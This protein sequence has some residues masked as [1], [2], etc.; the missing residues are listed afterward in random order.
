LKRSLLRGFKGRSAVSAGEPEEPIRSELFSIERLEQHAESLA[1]AQPVTPRPGAGRPLAARLRDNGRVLLAAYRAIG[2]AIRE[3]RAITPAAEWLVDN[4]H[5]VEEQIREIHDDLPRGFYRQLPKLADGPLA[6]YPRVF[7]LAWAFVAHTDSLFDPETL[8]R[9]VRAYQRVQP[10]T[11]GELWA[12]AITLRIVLVENLRR[13]AERIVRGRAA[14]QEADAL[15]DRLLGVG[16]REAEPIA[17][18][19]RGLD[20]TPLP[21]NFAAQLVQRLRDQDPAVTPAVRWL[22]DRL[23]AQGT[24]ADEIVRE[25]HQRQGA[26]NVTVRNVITSMRLLSAVDWAQFFE[27]V[28]LVDATLRAGS[29]FAAM[30]FPTRDRY[31][32][33]I[34]ALARGSS[35]S[36]LDVAGRALRAAKH[37]GD[38]PRSGDATVRREQDPGYYLIGR[39]RRAFEIELGFRVP[40][41]D[42]L[43]RAYAAAGILGY[44]GTVAIITACIL[45]PCVLVMAA[46]GV[47]GLALVLLAVLGLVPASDAAVALVNRHVTNRFDPK[48]LPAW[49]LREGVPPSL[50]TM[51]V[52]PTLLTT[53]AEIEEQVERL[54]VRYLASAEDDVRFALLSDWTDSSSECAPDDDALLGTATAAIDRLNQRYHPT[55]DGHRFILLHRRRVWN[56]REGKWIGWERKRGKLHELNRLLRG[57]TD[58]TF[59]SANGRP[60]VVPSGVRY[61]ITLDA[62]TRL[63]RGAA[64]Q[65]V[66]KMAHP[67]NRPELDPFTGRVVEGYGVLQPRVTPSLPTG[68][69]GSVFQRIFSGPSGIDPYAFAVSDV[70]QDLLGEGSF[71]GKGIYDVD[72]FEAALAGRVPENTLLSHDLLEGIFARAGLASDIE[73]VEEFPSRY[74]V[75]AAR[76]HRW[77][78]GDWQLL[79]WIFGRGRH[80]SGDPAR[81]P[82]PVIGRWKMLDNLRRTLSAPASFLALVAGWMLPAAPAVL[83]TGFVLAMI[84]LPALLPFVAGIVPR[85][86]GISKRSHLRAVGADLALGL[87]QTGLLLTLLAHQAWLMTDAI[88]RTL[89]R[90]CARQGRMLEWVTAAQAKFS[91][92][93]DIPGFYRRMAGGVAL[94]AAAAVVA[95]C[96]GYEGGLIAAPFVMLWTVSPVVAQWVSRPPPAA[97]PKPVSAANSHALRLIARRTWRFFETFVVA[98]DHMLPPDNFQEDPK[99]VVAHRTS[100]TNLGLY[101]LSVVAA[102]D[103]G[104][105]GTLE[106]VERLDATL[107]TMNHLERVRGHFYNWY[108]T[109]DLRPLDPT[110]VSS[111]DS[112]N[113]A[114]HLIALGSACRE[115]IGRPVLSPERFAGIADAVGLARAAVGAL[116][117]D[118]RTQTVTRKQLDEALETL[119][120][121]LEGSAAQTRG[122][123]TG[124]LDVLALH[125][126]TV[127]DIARTLTQERGEEADAD[128]LFW[129]E[130]V[131]ASIRSHQR[132]L[133]ELLP[134]AP[135]PFPDATRR[136]AARATDEGRGTGTDGYPLLHEALRACFE[137]APTLT[138]LPDRCDA[139][140]VILARHRAT[141]AAQPDATGDALGQ[142]DALIT[143]VEHSARAARALERRLVALADRAKKMC[144]AM[145][146]GFLFDPARQLLSIGY[147]VAEG[148]LDPNCYDL[149]ASEARLASFVAIA[150]GDVPLRH[151]F[152][153]GRALTPVD[154]G[155]ALIS[156]SGS[157]FEYLMPSLVMRAPA[158]SL[159]EQTSRFIVRR[160]MKYGAELDAPWG[161]SESAYNARDLELTYQY[162]NFGVPGLGLKRGLSEDIVVA[163]YATAL[164]AMVDSNAAAQNF[165]RLAAAGGQGRYGCYEA[166]D[167]TPARLPEGE[168]VA[169]VRTYMAH[170]QGMTVVAIA[171]ALDGGRMRARFHADP[172]VQATELLLQERTPRD[173]TVARP[174]AEEVKAAPNVRELVPPIVRRFRSPHSR[175]PRT[176][177]LS[178]GRYAVMLTSAGSGYSR[179]RDLAITR[180]REDVTCDSWGSYV[181]LRD[182]RN[183]A[184]WSAGYQ[185]S[186]VEPDSYA[187]SFSEDHAEISRRDGTIATTLEVAVS[188]EA[189]A[190]VR[191]VSLSNLGTRAR[192]IE[193]TSYAEIVLAPP[194]ADAAHPAFSKLFVHTEF[195]AD[196]G[197]LLATRRPRSPGDAPVWA[198]HLAVVEGESVGARQFETDR[199]R[200]LGRGRGIRTPISVIDGRPLSNTAG[201]VLDP[202]FS[203]QCRVRIP[204]ASTVRVAFWTL[205]AP[206]RSEALDLADKHHDSTAFQRAVTLAWTQAQVQLHH[207]GITPDEAHLFQRLANHVLFSDPT[208][209]PSAEVLKRNE[210]GQSTL[211]AQGISGD[212]PI[213]LV[214][215]DAVEDVEIVRQL[216]RA[217]EYWRLKRLAV[218]L[219]ILNERPSSY[220]AGLQEALE[221][222]VRASPARGHA[223]AEDVCGGVFVLRADLISLEVRILLQSVAR[224]VLLSRRGS[225]FEQVQRIEESEPAPP[226]SAPF[227]LLT[228]LTRDG[229]GSR[230]LRSKE[231]ARGRSASTAPETSLSRPEL[232]F[233]NGLGGFDAGGREYVTVL[234]AGQWTPAPWINVIAN[235]SFGFQASV[236]GA[237]YTWSISSRENQI[238]PWSNDPVGD[239]PGEVI[240]LRDEDSG[241]LW[242]PTAL[243]I[244]EES[245]PYVCRHGQGYTQFEHTAH[246]IS[247]EL[248]QYVPVDDPIKI[249]RLVIR[250]ES[251]RARRLSVTA[252]VEW[253]LAAAR[254][255]SAPFIVTEMDNATGALFARNHWR[256]ER[257]D[258]VAFADLGG[259]QVA[260][261]GDRTEFLG[262]NGTLDQPAALIGSVPLSNRVGA[263]FDSCGAL[264]ARLEL[265]PNERTEIVFFLGE[266]ATAAAARS[267]ITRYRTADL[268]AVLRGVTGQWD[269][270]LGTVQVRTPDRSMDILLNR[271]L[272]YQT[273][274]CRVWAR[275]AFYQASGAYGFRDQLQDVMALTVSRPDIA[276]AHLVRAAARQFVEGDVQHWWLA[277]A[278]QGVRTQV[279]DD[280]I[281]LPYATAHYVGVS[282]DFSVLDEVI[283]FLDGPGLHAGETDSYFQ[284]MVSEASGHL[285]EHC[286]RALDRSLSI[287]PHGL[288]LMGGGDWNDG[289]NRV[290]AG[291]HGESVWL[292]WFLYT[293]LSAFADLATRR[294]EP[295]RA[296][297]WQ[298]HAASLQDALEREAWD[299]D[300]YRRGYFDDG[301]PLGSA[302]SSE[303]R[304]DSIAQSWA[305]ISAAANPARAMRAMAAVEE[306]LLRRGDGLLVLFTPPFDRMNGHT[307]TGANG[308]EVRAEPQRNDATRPPA[309]FSGAPRGTEAS[310]VRA[311]S[312]LPNGGGPLAA[313]DPGYIKG[314]PPGIRENGGQYTHAAIWSLIAFAQLG[315]GDTAGELFSILNPINHSSTRSSVHRYKVE[316]YVIAAD[317]YATAPHVGRG[318]WTWYSGAAGWMYRA[319]LEWILGFHVR[320]AALL[321]DPC[322][323]KTWRG[324]EIV[325]RYRSARYDIT[326]ENPRGVSRGVSRIELDGALLDATDAGVGLVDDASIHRVRVVLG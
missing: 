109:R 261:T 42:W 292:G 66:G 230:P 239:R 282:G 182:T 268:D 300:W 115:M 305:V 280:C 110:Y 1:A 266:A 157:M 32:H 279:S 321:L 62:D 270:I 236:D 98:D 134:W 202:I 242:G 133:L 207:L 257:G 96:A 295:V 82:I 188:P 288:P 46:Y 281:W 160:Q 306:H 136:T 311:R 276:R 218:D 89:F 309:Q 153:L 172:M 57:A 151:W 146:F 38:P 94:A 154:R 253:V 128:V 101:L 223:E 226:F 248:L 159:L 229:S 119:E 187:V 163:P 3:E 193:L 34:E 200:F 149:L 31:R 184:V 112:G 24:T 326:V 43:I 162:C 320:G 126:D 111:V 52:V 152:R 44:V 252:Y 191:R 284:P 107:A 285:F 65:L 214:R 11:I 267:L 123:A 293:T 56:Q 222:I 63:P 238:T 195:V 175:V 180:W 55:A 36:E 190:E 68:R 41:R 301:T 277:P 174:R 140:L 40:M 185:P 240:Y 121:L 53:A 8:C 206:S 278:G 194:A 189:D 324:F 235:P 312:D 176:H 54:E 79:P 90:L 145:E 227:P 304:I 124:T 232:E 118:R 322:V 85:Q 323:P 2:A 108:D 213:V 167:Y 155:S 170:H 186:G 221:A 29:D 313:P 80:A 173:V 15:A 273:L 302:A 237:G 250:N 37:A 103:L 208:L 113:L 183:G 77:A 199:A 10:L 216:L 166:L 97:G 50:R 256:S 87:A 272:L 297:T 217:H 177:L 21:A 76:Q 308:S 61:V 211:W 100:P 161:V 243:P 210:R 299:G 78:R 127:T 156:W 263:A 254:E 91:L 198:A 303:C 179:W 13:L 48:M 318:G 20:R 114:G 17:A 106:T 224:A 12:V 58:T 105:L 259:R 104:W 132:D 129:A 83:W 9:F 203:L 7:G 158:G 178:N 139:A 215:I 296:R 70:Y 310:E 245:S 116:A 138:D 258:R 71:T 204:P 26:M 74:D 307:A 283:S 286:A 137:S 131:G 102:R 220:T 164:A 144:D 271:W 274:A 192:E 84:A 49:E 88:I 317:V 35:Y 28:S 265:R 16:T 219:V 93:L 181:F 231:G 69:E 6:G 249:S 86:L 125:A 92:P 27:S 75:T 135:L 18:T 289:M 315:D 73:V 319:G 233:F 47:G 150:K 298:Q 291:G 147:Q 251:G 244:R 255:A 169:I 205:I 148:S 122:D 25:E 262:R 196:V 269:S 117:D 168:P 33:A 171:N 30:D 143:A 275:S 165:S 241:V 99:P 60:P 260:W 234:A 294:G 39:G 228:S 72:I 246:G 209:R 23:I 225:L 45:V 130:A 4:F 316:P 14:R 67:L 141:I 314:Y 201:V 197:T 120:V 287:G 264:Q 19:L 22:D 51:V 142:A 5:V 325:F 64:R 81:R 59:L 95:A 212:L 290:G 247:V